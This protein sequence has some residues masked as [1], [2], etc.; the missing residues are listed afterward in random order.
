MRSH[1]SARKTAISELETALDGAR[2][3][4]NGSYPEHDNGCAPTTYLTDQKYIMNPIVS[5]GGTTYNE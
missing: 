3:E 1:D 5:P 2:L 4:N